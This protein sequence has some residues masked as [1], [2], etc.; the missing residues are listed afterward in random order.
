MP[1]TYY[2]VDEERANAIEEINK[3]KAELSDVTRMLCD[4]TKKAGYGNNASV[5]GLLDW[6]KKHDEMDKKRILAE[7]L[8]KKVDLDNKKREVKR[9]KS[10]LAKLKAEVK[11]LAD[12]IDDED[13]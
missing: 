3:L 6:I 2:T 5:P 9:K 12:Q 13:E 8:A 1:C 10:Q 4:L 11:A 7:E